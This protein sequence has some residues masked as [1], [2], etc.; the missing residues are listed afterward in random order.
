MKIKELIKIYEKLIPY[1]EETV[2]TKMVCYALDFG[3]CYAIYNIINV[4]E[5]QKYRNLC[6]EGYYKNIVRK[7]SLYFFLTYANNKSIKFSIIPRLE[8]M[9]KEITS[10]NKLLK[11]G[12]TD[13]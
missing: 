11:K 6:E 13:V 2:K 12:Y 4:K 9:K 3:I 10:L 7:N 5:Y 1:Y 8:F